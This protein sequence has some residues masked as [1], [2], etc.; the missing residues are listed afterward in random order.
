MIKT[1]DNALSA[2]NQQERLKTEGW[3]VGFID[4]EGCF[5]VSLHKNS[6]TVLGWQ[7][8][9]EFVAT[10][11]EKSLYALQQ[12]QE[13]FGCG[14]IFVNRRYDNHK[15][16]LYR[17]CVRSFADLEERI[18]PFFQTNQLRTAKAEDFK[19]FA[20]ILM[21]MK[22]KK[23]LSKVGIQEIISLAIQ[24]NTK[25]RKHLFLESSETTRQNAF[26]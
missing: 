23:H 17:F 9:P 1:T 10:Q 2:D 4:G 14:R 11:G 3:V 12:L 22:E 18:V 16:N 19:I 7:I 5:S 8:M 13:F 21:L 25:K 26:I 24:M 6:T 15:E 20:Q